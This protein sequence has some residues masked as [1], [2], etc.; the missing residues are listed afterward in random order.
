MRSKATKPKRIQSIRSLHSPCASK[1]QVL[2]VIRE[3]WNYPINKQNPLYTTTT[4]DYGSHKPS[5]HDMPAAFRG[6][7]SKFSEVRVFILA[8]QSG[9]SL[10]QL[11]TQYLEIHFV[12][13]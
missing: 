10:S 4:N 11:F 3:S 8:S 9:W 1:T 13:Y 6:Q 12:K 5:F 2:S 7:S